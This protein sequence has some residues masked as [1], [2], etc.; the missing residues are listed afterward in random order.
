[1]K[2]RINVLALMLSL[3]GGLFSCSQEEMVDIPDGKETC[4]VSLM[5]SMGDIQ[6]KAAPNYQYATLDELKI[7]NCHVAVFE[8]DN[9]GNPTNRIHSQNFSEEQMG[10]LNNKIIKDLSGYKLTL[11]N[12]RTFGKA[13]KAVRV[14][15]VANASDEFSACE[16]YESYVTLTSPSFSASSLVKVGLSEVVSLTYGATTDENTI[17]I[18][19]NQLSA[20]IEY[21]GIMVGDTYSKQFKLKKVANINTLS[22][23]TIFDIDKIE[24][25]D[26]KGNYYYKPMD[27]ELKNPETCSDQDPYVFY[28]YEGGQISLRVQ[29]GESKSTVKDFDLSD[30]EFVKG[31]L[32]RIKG[33]Y[34]PSLDI[35][36]TVVNM[37]SITVNIPEFD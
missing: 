20:K 26:N 8:L 18:S 27:L 22:K 36:W 10:G 15:I 11:R 30:N 29:L 19:L 6:T 4:D 16:S 17:P 25:K 7:S 24:N 33:T 14:L 3:L 35:K 32:Y 37:G 23:I 12:V 9:K 2:L 13:P 31:N 1:M 21:M 5:I 28:T 34:T